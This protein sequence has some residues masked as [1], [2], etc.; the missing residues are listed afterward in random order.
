MLLL[1]FRWVW[2]RTWD[3]RFYWSLMQPPWNIHIYICI[4]ICINIIHGIQ[5]IGPMLCPFSSRLVVFLPRLYKK[6]K[7]CHLENIFSR[8][9]AIWKCPKVITFH[10]STDKAE[11]L[12]KRMRCTLSLSQ[13]NCITLSE[14]LQSVL[15]LLQRQTSTQSLCEKDN[16]V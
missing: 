9:L 12:S 4:Y 1:F 14:Y 7:K 5:Y 13:L 8:K 16:E 10:R 15:W 6:R 2:D 11:I 3:C